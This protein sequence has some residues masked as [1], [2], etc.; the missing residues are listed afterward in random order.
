MKRKLYT[1]IVFTLICAKVNAQCSGN[2]LSG[3]VTILSPVKDKVLSYNIY[4]GFTLI[5]GSATLPVV[6]A[7][8]YNH[9]FTKEGNPNCQD[10][11][12]NPPLQPA[13]YD[14]LKRDTLIDNNIF[15]N[16]VLVNY[17]TTIIP[18]AGTLGTMT[19]SAF[20]NSCVSKAKGSTCITVNPFGAGMPLTGDIQ[21][22]GFG[23]SINP[24]QNSHAYAISLGD[25]TA[26]STKKLKNGTI[27]WV[28]WVQSMS[29]G[30][31]HGIRLKGGTSDP[32]T[33]FVHD[34]NT[35][36]DFAG[37]LLTISMTFYTDTDTF[38]YINKW[39]NDTVRIESDSAEFHIAFPSS[40]TNPQGTLLVTVGGGVVTAATG[41]GIF[42]SVPLP[43]INSP[44]PVV[45][46]L[47]NLL[48]F[49]YDL[50]NFNNDSLLVIINM[51]GN[52]I[53]NDVP[54][55]VLLEINDSINTPKC[56]GDKTGSIYLTVNGDNPPFTYLWNNGST[57]KKRLNLKANTYTVTVT[58]SHGSTQSKTMVVTEPATLKVT[59]TKTNVKC[60]GTSTGTA[61][62]TGKDGTPGY[63]YAWNTGDT[64]STITSLPAG[65]YT[66]VVTDANNCIVAKTIVI[67]ENPPLF[68]TATSLGGD[69]A[70]ATAIGGVPGYTFRWF[71]IPP[72]Y[73]A[74]AIGLIS[75]N[76]YKVKV[77]DS[78]F[79]TATIFYT[80]PFSRMGDQLN[81]E[82]QVSVTPNPTT[83]L[84]TVHFEKSTSGHCSIKLFDVTGKLLYEKEMTATGNDF[85]FDFSWLQKG[86]YVLSISDG[87]KARMIKL[88]RN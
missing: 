85:N 5:P 84:V 59:I 23:Q 13:G 53:N 68:L 6:K 75:G 63:S 45:F 71:T 86:V 55:S 12:V 76:T 4:H 19:D 22:Y 32:I 69:S 74:K 7:I 73:T 62:A 56:H 35:G 14:S 10:S 88:V 17:K 57:A 16:Q 66:V 20:S 38:T 42:A 72:Q 15:N 49:Q 11:K 29:T 40:L 50:G 78:K 48:Q 36:L 44:T 33:Y 79:C 30:K 83:G 64:T 81:E 37:T 25:V 26:E 58:D 46:P 21:S 70:T 3:K 87:D 39:K 51:Y 1:F 65:T 27:I 34:Y 24:P 67:T 9:S 18:P 47:Q 80:H 52:S 43:P 60:W 28:P 31:A 82:S 61:T 54:A 2:E 8:T 41:T 77:T